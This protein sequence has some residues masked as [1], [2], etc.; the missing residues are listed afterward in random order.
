MEVETA[1]AR[2]REA[3]IEINNSATNQDMKT[4]LEKTWLLQDRLVFPDRV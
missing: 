4:T 2:L 3:T 1:L